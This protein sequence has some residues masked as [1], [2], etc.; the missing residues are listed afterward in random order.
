[1]TDL[2][3]T[4]LDADGLYKGEWNALVERGT[5]ARE[6]HDQSQWEIGAI[7]L[8]IMDKWSHKGALK[9]FA[10]QIGISERSAQ[11]YRKVAELFPDDPTDS[12]NE[13]PVRFSIARAASGTDEPGMWVNRAE[14][15]GWST[16]ELLLK[17]RTDR[18]EREAANLSRSVGQPP[19]E[20]TGEPEASEQSRGAM[21]GG[22]WPLPVNEPEGCEHEFVCRLC[23]VLEGEE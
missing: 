10:E 19:Q 2:S 13:Q 22:D 23:G 5:K 3:Y 12:E 18:A 21:P 7:A 15:F 16:D 1:M 4:D 14:E 17:I 8:Q 6:Q 9:L 11:Q 20:P